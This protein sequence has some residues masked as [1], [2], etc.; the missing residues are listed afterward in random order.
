[1]CPPV[2]Q[3]GPKRPHP[4][5]RSARHAAPPRAPQRPLRWRPLE[6]SCSHV[7]PQWRQPPRGSAPTTPR[8]CGSHAIHRPRSSRPV[9]S[10]LGHRQFPN[11]G[12]IAPLGWATVISL[13][14]RRQRP[15]PTRPRRRDR[16]AASRLTTATSWRQPRSNHPRWHAP[17]PTQVAPFSPPPSSAPP[18]RQ[19][20]HGW[21]P[22]TPSPCHCQR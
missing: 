18:R 12:E 10:G 11:P 3:A 6:R 17:S 8:C 21:P 9:Q 7:A 22:Q 5:A 13:R 19:R 1:M 4:T 20:H 16:R 14:H 15:P 2:A